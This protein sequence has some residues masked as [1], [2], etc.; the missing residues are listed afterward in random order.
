MSY[1][2]YP[3]PYGSGLPLNVN[4]YLREP[5]FRSLV[6]EPFLSQA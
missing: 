3:Q 4:G 6:S 2:V 1:P 5:D